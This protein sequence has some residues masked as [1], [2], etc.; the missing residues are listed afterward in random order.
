MPQNRNSWKINL[1]HTVHSSFAS[2][3]FFS[4][5]WLKLNYVILKIEFID[6]KNQLYW[7]TLMP[8]RKLSL[9]TAELCNELFKNLLSSNF[10]ANARSQ[11]GW[12]WIWLIWT[13]DFRL[14]CLWTMFCA[15]IL[16]FKIFPECIHYSSNPEFSII[17]TQKSS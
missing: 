10:I 11:M 3:V 14:F 8:F 7:W 15:L 17:K 2:I 4:A 16:I 6:E 1:S 5:E 13:S 12:F 9:N